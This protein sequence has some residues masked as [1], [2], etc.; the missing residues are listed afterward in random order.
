ML[1]PPQPAPL[2]FLQ[3]HAS[4]LGKE[5]RTTPTLGAET[6]EHQYFI[7]KTNYIAVYKSH[8]AV[9][10]FI[11]VVQNTYGTAGPSGDTGLLGHTGGRGREGA[12]Q[13]LAGT[14]QR[15]DPGVLENKGRRWAL[16]RG[17][18]GGCPCVREPGAP[19]MCSDG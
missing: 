1:P 8:R 11:E 18:A 5:F 2:L 7:A 17:E 3:E 16:G 15:E 9:C 4:I 19:I 6:F 14:K 13:E 12:G 10:S